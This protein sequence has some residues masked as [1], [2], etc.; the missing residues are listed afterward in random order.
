MK[1]EQF[2]NGI[3][4][5][6]TDGMSDS[7]IWTYLNTHVKPYKVI[8][9]GIKAGKSNK[10]IQKDFGLNITPGDLTHSERGTGG[11]TSPPA[12]LPIPEM[13]SP[14]TT[15]P[16]LQQDRSLIGSLPVPESALPGFVPP[17]P[18]PYS[19]HGE[20]TA[21]KK[22]QQESVQ[23]FWTGKG[24]YVPL[25]EWEKGIQKEKDIERLKN[26]P[27]A[28]D[29]RIESFVN[30][31]LPIQPT[32]HPYAAEAYPIANLAGKLAPNIFFMMMGGGG[33]PGMAKKA[34]ENSAWANL[35]AL[36]TGDP[37]KAAQTLEILSNSAKMF[38]H[39][40]VRELADQAAR[41]FAGED[42]TPGRFIKKT[43]K[44][45]VYGGL[46][47]GFDAIASTTPRLIAT[48]VG[49]SMY[50]T[51]VAAYNDGEISKE[52]LQDIVINA[53]FDTALNYFGSKDLQGQF[54]ALKIYKEMELDNYLSA[55]QA[56]KPIKAMAKG[57]AKQF[58]AKQVMD[59]ISIPAYSAII[60]TKFPGFAKLEKD[61]Q[62]N[63]L[64]TVIDNYKQGMPLDESIDLV[65][66]QLKPDFDSHVDELF[67]Q[68]KKSANIEP[69]P[70]K[71][72]DLSVYRPKEG[73]PGV[74]VI[75]IL[76]KKKSAIY[77][78]KIPGAKP[79]VGTKP[80]DIFTGK[81][82]VEGIKDSETIK[83][84]V[85][86]GNKMPT[87]ITKND[88]GNI[89]KDVDEVI[90]GRALNEVMPEQKQV[91]WK[92]QEQSG[93]SPKK[94]KEE[95]RKIVNV[96]SIDDMTE[97]EAYTVISKH[98]D[99]I[100]KK[101][102]KLLKSAF[103][104]NEKK[105][106]IIDNQLQ[107]TAD[108]TR[109]LSDYEFYKEGDNL[110]KTFDRLAKQDEDAIKM[111][112]KDLLDDYKDSSVIS[113]FVPVRFEFRRDKN[114]WKL[115]KR[116]HRNTEN[117]EAFL[118]Q[119][120]REANE[121]SRGLTV[122]ELNQISD[123]R[124]G[125]EGVT[126][127]KKQQKFNDFLQTRYDK[128][129]K[130]FNVG[131]SAGY[132]NTYNPRQHNKSIIDME[133]ELVNRLFG[134]VSDKGILKKGSNLPAQLDEYFKKKRTQAEA[135]DV[136]RNSLKIFKDYM[137]VGSK[138]L[139]YGN[140]IQR[141]RKTIPRLK[142]GMAT[143]MEDYIIR[144]LGYPAAGESKF[145]ETLSDAVKYFKKDFE[146][147]DQD[148][149]QRMARIAIDINYVRAMGARPTMA[150]KQILQ[151]INN[152]IPELG[153]RYTQ[154][155]FRKMLTKGMKEAKE[156]DLFM[157]FAPSLY[158]EISIDRS[159]WDKVRDGLLFF[160]SQM[161]KVNR[162]IAYYGANDKFDDAFKSFGKSKD[163]KK[164]LH[165]IEADKFHKRLREDL[166]DAMELGNYKKAKTIFA[167]EIVAKTQY[168]YN[169]ANSPIFTRTS[170][171]KLT[172]QFSSWPAN[173]GELI[174]ENV[175]QKNW[176][177]MARRV[178]IYSSLMGT[179]SS[180]YPDTKEGRRKKRFVG[181]SIMTGPFKGSFE[182]GLIPPA[183]DPPVETI[184]MLE[185][186]VE[187]MAESTYD[188]NAVKKW[189]K[190]YGKNMYSFKKYWPIIF[191]DLQR[192]TE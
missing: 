190:K 6:R 173:Y 183:L 115:F 105:D 160:H 153:L 96:D 135:G 126:L 40:G 117:Y 178:A 109:K 77:Q 22:T 83:K 79:E 121:A 177:A 11:L 137:R 69:P 53:A 98:E 42:I 100:L 76:S 186:L 92:L 59:D 149:A 132:Q 175:K 48:A 35:A 164:F 25:P 3:E 36:Q 188:K 114:A 47:G 144:M 13:A 91:Y 138:N 9:R 63:I 136:E 90:E 163:L 82:R 41:V 166:I 182:Y 14:A 23:G 116:V 24:E 27:Y 167:K 106:E 134:E 7:Q 97:R 64:A 139:Y 86:A 131:A 171:G 191:K 95:T 67:T 61:I 152:T 32:T 147:F 37:V 162:T 129:F 19:E 102:E 60:E 10:E 44:Q 17:A 1:R 145:T 159:N 127:S 156:A 94:F 192:W 52:D 56:V 189:K 172:Y 30:G 151:T 38:S 148:T 8:H 113:R 26:S 108:I 88:P 110:V 112:P 93:M 2:F 43:A 34:V 146:G 154:K 170:A 169:K 21:P 55:R 46:S 103:V 18:M 87:W 81:E 74:K 174:L 150:I 187:A 49:S 107:R 54:D 101:E 4:K 62:G 73:E 157:E 128:A 118:H 85:L 161:D 125:V 89:E 99:M 66:S 71:V 50:E 28:G 122:D 165:K 143:D 5:M 111:I 133:Q 65:S 155:G 140:L 180:I 12:S 39:F 45:A 70:A 33:I 80:V 185:Q 168:L 20:L 142:P 181:R 158:K 123:F 119:T 72:M 176:K 31:V 120:Y 124:E 51:A 75:D 78:D 58:S 84:P 130:L 15:G 29:A 57:A 179:V 141:A 68:V 104:T 16:Q 184:V